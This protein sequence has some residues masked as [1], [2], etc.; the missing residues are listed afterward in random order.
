MK[1]IEKALV[2]FKTAS[3]K[4][5]LR[6]NEIPS[7][8]VWGETLPEVWEN[9]VVA[10]ITLG[11]HIPT[12]YDQEV[13]L[14]SYDATVM[15]TIANPLG[16]PRIHKALPCGYDDLEIYV[17]EVVDGVHDHWVGSHGWSY[18]YH[19]RLTNWPGIGSEEFD[20]PYI[21]QIDELVNKLTQAPHSRRAQA[22]TWV[23]FVDAQHHESPCLQRIWCRVVKSQEEK[24]L[25]QM[26]THWRSRDA[27]KASFMNI[28]ALTLLQEE[29]AKKIS[30]VSGKNVGVG[31][32]VDV[33]DSF[34]I[35]GSYIRKGEVE[36]FVKNI[37]GKPFA[38]RVVR[39]DNSLI[40][41]EFARGR[42][43]LAKEKAV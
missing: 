21:N 7:I 12:E 31:R 4:E 33:S 38:S 15:L 39:S 11:A 28:Y 23:P 34:H 27:F 22:I 9:A 2:R 30:D 18:S 19:D 42:E 13:D 25:L 43:K 8:A 41:K 1:E 37:E 17:R 40:Q 26:N 6:P 35:Y 20:L 16:E 10:T 24:Y 36:K 3:Y 5:G 29:I 32:Y 14:E